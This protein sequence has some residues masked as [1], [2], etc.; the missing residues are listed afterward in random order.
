MIF[1]L[2]CRRFDKMMMFATKLCHTFLFYPIH[3]SIE[4]TGWYSKKQDVEKP[5]TNVSPLKPASCSQL[6]AWK[7]LSNYT[8]SPVQ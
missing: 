8:V 3:E 7:A 1:H 6:L 5:L 4:K 2:E